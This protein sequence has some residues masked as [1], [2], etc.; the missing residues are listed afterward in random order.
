[1]AKLSMRTARR[2][3]LDTEIDLLMEDGESFNVA[4][5]IASKR[6]KEM[7]EIALDRHAAEPIDFELL[8]F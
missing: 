4:L 6:L 1:M 8:P 3:A 7:E 2:E 5:Q